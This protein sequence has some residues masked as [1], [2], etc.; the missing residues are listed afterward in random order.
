[1]GYDIRLRLY[2]PEGVKGRVL[3]TRKINHNVT[4]N[5]TPLLEFTVSDRVASG[6]DAPFMV[7]VE[8]SKTGRSW[9]V[10]KNNLYIVREDGEDSSLRDVKTFTGVGIVGW[11][12]SVG[13]HWAHPT[14]LNKRPYDGSPGKVLRSMIGEAQVRDVATAMTYTFTDTKD[15]LGQ[16]WTADDKIK[17]E[18][19]LWRPM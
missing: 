7:G 14:N 12:L 10:P 1:M 3:T 5:G 2:T 15:S 11:W 19:E 18:L 16:T 13:I 9:V 8:V 6:L 4:R 17:M